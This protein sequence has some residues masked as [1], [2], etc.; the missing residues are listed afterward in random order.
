MF[1]CFWFLQ[2]IQPVV[3]LEDEDTNSTVHL[4]YSVTVLHQSVVM[5]CVVPEIPWHKARR[6]RPVFKIMGMTIFLML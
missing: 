6:I 3:E 5:H 2:P 1:K 4:A